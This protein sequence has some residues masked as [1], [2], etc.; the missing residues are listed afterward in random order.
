MKGERTDSKITSEYFEN[1]L[2]KKVTQYSLG[3]LFAANL[4]GIWISILLIWPTIGNIIQP[5]SYGRWM[6]LHME[7]QLYG[8]CSLPLLGILLKIYFLPNQKGILDC[9]VIFNAWSVALVIGGISWLS[10]NVSGKLFLNWHGFSRILFSLTL[11]LVWSIL[12]SHVYYEYKYSLDIKTIST[13][14]FRILKVLFLLV[15]LAI[16]VMIYVSSSNKSYP[17]VNPESGG[18]T[19]HNLLLS[20]TMIMI[21]FAGIPYFLKCEIKK[22]SKPLKLF[23][24]YIIICLITYS[25]ISHGNASNRSLDQI[26]GM[27]ILLLSIPILSI[28]YLSF[29]WHANSKKW[30][31]AFIAWWGVLTLTG[32][33]TFLPEILVKQKFTNALVAHTHLAMAGMLTSINILILL[34]LSRDCKISSPLQSHRLF[35]LWQYG[36]LIYVCSMSLLSWLEAM[37]PD[38]IFQLHKVTIVNYTVRLIAGSMMT[39]SSLLWFLGSVTKMNLPFL[40]AEINSN[41]I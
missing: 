12:V 4:V 31:T 30:M 19:G 26:I 20:T 13:K 15:M 6:P 7:W 34:N 27:G 24:A 11:V 28:F 17:P 40:Q 5:L 32:F 36:C 21:I 9:K 3:W 22:N 14:Y 29:Q 8:W 2:Q 25:F 1:Y 39:L 38:I 35:S 16:P 33:L 41:E 23:S 10:G 18:A 37:Q